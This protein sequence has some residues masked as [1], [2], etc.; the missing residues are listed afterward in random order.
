MFILSTEAEENYG[1]NLSLKNVEMQKRDLTK[2]E[3]TTQRREKTAHAPFFCLHKKSI[4][5]EICFLYSRKTTDSVRGK[6][7]FW[8]TKTN[9]SQ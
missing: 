3:H 1:K 6:K 2:T 5:T 9:L 4:L 8:E 7:A